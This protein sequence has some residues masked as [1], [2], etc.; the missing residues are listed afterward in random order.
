MWQKQEN[1]LYRKFKFKDFEEAFSFIE[2]VAELAKAS[3]HHP[4]IKN[5]F[6]VVELWL[7]TH[8]SG[9]VTGK[10]RELADKIDGITNQKKE[11]RTTNLTQAKLFTDGGSRGNPGPSAIGVVILDMDDSVVKKSSK[12]IGETTNNQAEY[13]AL[14]EGLEITRQLG[15]K[16]LEVYM[17]SE[18][19]VK[20]VKGEYKVKNQ[21]LRPIYLD[22]MSQ[23]KK[24]DAVSF[25]HVPRELNK[26]ADGLV[27]E[28]LDKQ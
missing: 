22:V 23:V 18:L 19:I 11:S 1:S 5:N 28:A 20:Q 24:F 12:Y 27:N 21:D 14:K 17:D 15:V 4:E 9:G 25:T 26:I 10:D 16:K 7:T 6:N 2:S 13:K 8:S 3:N